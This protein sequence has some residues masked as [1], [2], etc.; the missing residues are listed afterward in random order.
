MCPEP[1]SGERARAGRDAWLAAA[2]ALGGTDES[3]ANA[4]VGDRRASA[5]WTAC[6]ATVPLLAS[7]LAPRTGPAPHG[8]RAVVRTPRSRTHL[9]SVSS[10]AH[11][12]DGRRALLQQR[13][14]AAKRRALLTAALADIAG[15]WPQEEVA[16]SAD[17]ARRCRC[18]VRARPIAPRSWPRAAPLCPWTAISRRRRAGLRCSASGALGA[19]E[20]T[21]SSA[22][23]L[24]VLFDPERVQHR[25]RGE[26]TETLHRLVRDLAT[27]LGER[28][29]DGCVYRTDLR[30]QAQHGSDAAGALRSRRRN[31]TTRVTARTG[32][33]PR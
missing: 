16:A 2:A 30:L 13:L 11:R 21:Y 22:L 17:P 5:S 25:G 9:K 32:S 12:P 23:N 33:A 20:L 28:T 18:C 6:S 24:F 4:L 29:D 15:A 1:A 7:W 27:L 8:G 31:S 3:F 14:R 19:G 26:P 10:I